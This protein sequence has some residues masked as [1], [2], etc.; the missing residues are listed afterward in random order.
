MFNIYISFNIPLP[1]LG[2]IFYILWQSW[3][4][5]LKFTI[6]RSFNQSTWTNLGYPITRCISSQT[7]YFYLNGAHNLDHVDSLFINCQIYINF[8]LANT[9]V[10]YWPTRKLSTQRRLM[11]CLLLTLKSRSG[12]RTNLTLDWTFLICPTTLMVTMLSLNYLKESIF[13]S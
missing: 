1:W 12:F 2:I 6:L 9:F 13:E 11:K 7:S 3:T 4:K 8:S 10:F 5:L